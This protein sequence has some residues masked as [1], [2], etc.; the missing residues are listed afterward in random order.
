MENEGTAVYAQ[1]MLTL[2]GT[3]LRRVRL[4]YARGRTWQQ[5]PYRV[6]P[7]LTAVPTAAPMRSGG[8]KGTPGAPSARAG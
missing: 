4:W 7:P 1:D 8:P 3:W 2:P 6:A 5:G